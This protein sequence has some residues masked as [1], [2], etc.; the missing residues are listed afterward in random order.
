MLGASVSCR[1]QAN[2]VP[3]WQLLRWEQAAAGTTPK[4][5]KAPQT[6][7]RGLASLPN[8]FVVLLVGPGRLELPTNGL[9]VRCSTN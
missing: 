5:P 4:H 7:K 6:N 3:W 1:T 9:R 8:P 2:D